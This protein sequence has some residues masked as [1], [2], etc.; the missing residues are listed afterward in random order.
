MRSHIITPKLSDSN[1]HPVMLPSFLNAHCELTLPIFDVRV[2]P[3]WV[4][5]PRFLS[6]IDHEYCPWSMVRLGNS[7]ARRRNSILF[8]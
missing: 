7:H 5:I 3:V 6:A 8:R 1:R 2:L 4:A